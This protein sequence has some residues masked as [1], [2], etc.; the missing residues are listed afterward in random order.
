MIKKRVKKMSAIKA[1]REQLEKKIPKRCPY[2]AVDGVEWT[3]FEVL[4]CQPQF[5]DTANNSW[6]ESKAEPFTRI[7]CTRCGMQMKW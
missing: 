1:V 2:C 7:V 3:E 5:F 6:H 4:Y